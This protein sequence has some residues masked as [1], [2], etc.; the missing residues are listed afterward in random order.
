MPEN[1][2]AHVEGDTFDKQKAYVPQPEGVF[3]SRESE[4]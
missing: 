3:V 1:T 2:M 4:S